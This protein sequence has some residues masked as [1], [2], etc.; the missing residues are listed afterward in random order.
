MPR[1]EDTTTLPK[2]T[3]KPQTP[4]APKPGI[5]QDGTFKN[6]V[7]D[8]SME[9]VDTLKLHIEG[10]QWSVT[11]LRQLLA[12]GD[13]PASFQPNQLTPYQQYERINK[14]PLRV[15]SPLTTTPVPETDEFIVEGS[16]VIPFA[17]T[18][19]V[20]DAFIADIGD[21]R[22][23]ILS[24]NACVRKTILLDACY[25]VSYT[26]TGYLTEEHEK[27]INDCVVRE[28]FYSA[29][30]VG[31]GRGPLLAESDL[32]NYRKILELEPRLAMAIYESAYDEN[33]N[34]FLL[35]QQK[36][37]D[38]AMGLS[39]GRGCYDGM[40]VKVFNQ[41]VGDKALDLKRRPLELTINGDRHFDTTIWKML[42]EGQYDHFT[43]PNK[44]FTKDRAGLY[45]IDLI[46]K[47]V[48]MT[49]VR[50][51]IMP[52]TKT[53]NDKFIYVFTEAFY[54]GD[55]TGMTELEKLTDDYLA[56]RTL[57]QEMLLGALDDFVNWTPLDKLYLG[58]VALLL[59]RIVLQ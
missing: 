40:V 13:E 16:S 31:S 22:L 25:E 39:I 47:G 53:P 15:I 19:N 6:A 41:I 20:G 45:A 38:N 48:T 7:V 56:G 49:Q 54:D 2:P 9:R 52:D 3:V 46:F 10:S 58:T 1:F 43:K 21:G 14:Y 4:S 44:Y 28:L 17:I 57:N 55:R 18:P 12:S 59:V 11:Y 30:H 33:T 24:I 51:I 27:K 42:L 29:D 8:M 50:E 37:E 23:G 5:E 34:T 36:A 32:N 35:P 26:L